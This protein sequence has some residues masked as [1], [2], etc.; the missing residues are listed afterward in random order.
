MKHL[1]TILTGAKRGTLD[2]FSPSV[3]SPHVS[4]WKPS[5]KSGSW[6]DEYLIGLHH[7][8]GTFEGTNPRHDG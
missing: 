4:T 7:Q 5:L 2:K 8:N 6:G 1:G 3:W